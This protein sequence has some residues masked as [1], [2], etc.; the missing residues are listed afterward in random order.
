[1]ESGVPWRTTAHC[2]KSDK[3]DVKKVVQIVLKNKLLEEIGVRGIQATAPMGGR[4]DKV[5]DQ[6]KFEKY[7]G[8]F[9]ADISE[10]DIEFP[11]EHDLGQDI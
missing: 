11:T 7:R 6:G 3:D 5:L 10:V 2:T 8:S 9:R 4:E 1:M